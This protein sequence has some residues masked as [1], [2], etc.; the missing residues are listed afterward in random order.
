MSRSTLLHHLPL[1][2]TPRYLPSFPGLRAD[3]R[4]NT[5]WR[6]R[7]RVVRDGDV[8]VPPGTTGGGLM[9]QMGFGSTHT[10]STTSGRCVSPSPCPA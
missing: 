3:E 4:T 7:G 1:H 6:G 8:A 5:I 10:P 2:P 9:V